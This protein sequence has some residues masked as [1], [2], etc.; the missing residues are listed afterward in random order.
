MR[1]YFFFILLGTSLTGAAPGPKPHPRIAGVV[2]EISAQK[3]EASIRKLVSFGTRH[4]LSDTASE[5]RGIGAARRWLQA[6]FERYAKDSGGRLEV[7]MDEFTQPPGESGGGGRGVVGAD[8]G[9][10][11]ATGAPGSGAGPAAGAGVKA[12]RRASPP[13][14][15][16]EAALKTDKRLDRRPAG[17]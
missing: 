5:A 16:L 4:T 12:A 10:A 15:G 1:R 3:I 2:S 11:D 7:T 8:A 14:A 6:E 17:T 9:L 13:E